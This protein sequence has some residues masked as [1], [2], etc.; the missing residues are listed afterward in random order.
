MA[1]TL[2]NLGMANGWKEY[3]PIVCACL[4]AKHPQQ[5]RTIGRCLTEFRCETCGYRY[6]VDSSD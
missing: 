2:V 4:D 1:P 5:Q 3:P 6:E